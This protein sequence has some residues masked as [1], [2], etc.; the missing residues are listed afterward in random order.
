[1]SCEIVWVGVLNICSLSREL[2]HA[3]RQDVYERY[4]ELK[5]RERQLDRDSEWCLNYSILTRPKK[6]SEEKARFLYAVINK[7]FSFSYYN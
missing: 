4:S 3:Y 7:I 2:N 6:R 1:M 5:E